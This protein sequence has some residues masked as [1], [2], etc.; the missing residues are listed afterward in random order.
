MCSCHFEYV[1]AS[2]M[3][4]VVVDASTVCVSSQMRWHK[5]RRWETRARARTSSANSRNII[6]RFPDLSLIRVHLQ[7][8]ALSAPVENDIS[9]KG[10]V[11]M[12]EKLYCVCPSVYRGG[13][14][15]TLRTT[16]WL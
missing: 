10:I 5:V 13:W 8:G 3:L 11:K 15:P 6:L 4:A 7:L 16:Y 14:M 12:V 1:V 9:R 2:A